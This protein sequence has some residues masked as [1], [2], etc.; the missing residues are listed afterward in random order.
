MEKLINFD[1]LK[2]KQNE[3]PEKDNIFLASELQ[4]EDVYEASMN[5]ANYL[6]TEKISNVMFLDNSARQAYVG[7]KE[8]WKKIDDEERCPNIYFI[9]PEALRDDGDFEFYKEEFLNNYKN[10]N[11]EETLLLYDACIHTGGSMFNTKEFFKYLGFKDIRVAVTSTNE[12]FPKNKYD[13]LDLICLDHRATAGCRPFGRSE[14]IKN[15]PGKIISKSA[16]SDESLELGQMQHQRIK[17]VF[18]EEY[19]KNNT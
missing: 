12:R 9:N 11:P 4:K 16:K 7:L 1:S 5:L 18:N 3:S 8:A 17:E 13:Q 10:L 19:E 6:K 15:N 14:Y 2:L